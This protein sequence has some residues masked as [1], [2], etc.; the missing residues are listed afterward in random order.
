MDLA[1][2]P[3][4][5]PVTAS[6]AR[7]AAVTPAERRIYADA[8]YALLADARRHR[9]SGRPD[10]AGTAKGCLRYVLSLVRPAR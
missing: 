2:F 10:M 7:R 8:A 3:G 6:P 9:L 5:A 4:R 1:T